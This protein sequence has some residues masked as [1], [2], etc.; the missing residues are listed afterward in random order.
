MEEHGTDF[1]QGL[2]SGCFL[3]LEKNK[4]SRREATSKEGLELYQ[5]LD[6]GIDWVEGVHACMGQ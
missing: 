1:K 6:E 3:H 2:V 5:R 4:G